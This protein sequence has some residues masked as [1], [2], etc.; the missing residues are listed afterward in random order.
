MTTKQVQNQNGTTEYVVQGTGNTLVFLHGAGASAIANWQSSIELFSKSHKVISINLPSAGNT[1][2]TKQELSLEDLAKVVKSVIENENEKSVT[3][4]GY[5][6]GAIVAL[7]F[8]GIF[9]SETKSVIAL[10]PWLANARQKFFFNFWGKLLKTDKELFARY[11]TITA[12][13]INAHGYMNDEAFEGTAQVFS[14]TGF[15]DDLPLLIETL[16]TVNIEPYLSDIKAKTKIIGFTFDLIAPINQAKEISDKVNGAVYAEIQA[17][18]AGPWEA[19]E[20]MNKEIAN[21]I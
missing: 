1:T 19:T 15:N 17:G 6:T 8:A 14:N 7:A 3:L 4:I 5:S 13:S 9:E 12:L 18:H 21:F 20:K 11:N 10:A 2:W 16:T